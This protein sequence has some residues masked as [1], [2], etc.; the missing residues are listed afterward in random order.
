MKQLFALLTAVCATALSAQAAPSVLT[1]PA[2]GG[3]IRI[4]PIFHASMKI[5]YGGK[6]IY[7]DPV[8]AGD[9]SAGKKADLILITDIHGDHLDEAALSDIVKGSSIIV[10]PQAVIEKLEGDKGH[11]VRLDI[12]KTTTQ[13][14]FLIGALPMY[15]LVRGPKPGEKFHPKGRGNGYVL[16]LGGKRIYIAGD[17]EV[18]PEMKKLKNID[19]A[20]LPMN[21]PFTMTPQEAAQGAKIFMPKVAIPYHYRYPFDKA[22]DNPQQFQAAL[23]GIKIQVRLLEW[24]PTAAVQK[25]THK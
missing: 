10:A 24:Y 21:L 5:E 16:T 25:A 4:T 22:N 23:K 15:N 9:Y 17:T 3:P 7:V 6:T 2:K 11:S 20:F 13:A 19:L 8:S 18:T 12:G 1:V 14:G